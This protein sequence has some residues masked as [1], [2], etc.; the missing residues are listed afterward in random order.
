M[1][2]CVQNPGSVVGQTPWSAA[3]AP[4]GRMGIGRSLRQRDQG[5][6]RGPGGPPHL[7]RISSEEESGLEQDQHWNTCSLGLLF[8][9]ALAAAPP[10]A[11]TV[12]NERISNTPVDKRI[13]G[14][15]LEH[16][17]Q[18]MDTMWAELLQDNSF[19]G[20]REFSDPRERWAEGPI[21]SSRFWWHSGYEL[22]PWR[23]VGAGGEHGLGRE[24]PARHAG[25]GDC[26]PRR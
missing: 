5:V 4:V 10:I 21:D 19:E 25:E 18:Q 20:L 15:L 2:K 13:Y 16:I 11:I 14:V 24:H 17:G 1:N 23:T 7:G 26:E 22:H 8:A 3:D 12:S 9:V 6:P